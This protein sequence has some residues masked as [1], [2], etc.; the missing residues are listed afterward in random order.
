MWLK[1]DICWRQ[2]CIRQLNNDIIE[3][4]I[5]I[6]HRVRERRM[7]SSR[8]RIT[9][10]NRN[11]QR[12]RSRIEFFINRR[13]DLKSTALQTKSISIS[14]AKH[15]KEIQKKEIQSKRAKE[16][17][18][19][20][21]EVTIYENQNMTNKFLAIM[22]EFN[23]WKE[24]DISVII[25]LKNHM[26]IDLKSNWADKIKSNKIYLLKS[27]KRFIINEIFDNLHAKEKMKWF[28]N[29]TSFEYLVFVI[30]RT[31]MKDDK[32][33]R[34][35]WAVINIRELNAIIVSDAYLMSAQTEIIAAVAQCQYISIINVLEYFYQW[36]IKFD[37]RHKF[38]IIS[39]RDEK[40]FN[41]YVMNYK[42]SSS[43]VQRQTNLMLKNLRNFVRTYMNDIIIFF[44][45]LN[46]HLLHLREIF[47]RLWYYNVVLN[48]KKAFL[49]YSFI[50]LLNQIID[51][52][53]L[54]IAEKKLVAIANLIFSLILKEL[55]FF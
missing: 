20:T 13:R 17:I 51:V 33:V 40:Q 26:S 11:V 35:K 52:L 49:K 44:K 54:I 43:Y 7:L 32:F 41:V 21:N 16:K 3:N 30:Y 14:Y 29:S 55:K 36:A 45:T 28:T 18:K 48:L 15:K 2:K 8:D 38:T 53:K 46:D 50:I 23:V 42:N 25:S 4:T 39:H 22:I 1:S 31:I 27:N 10:V 34:K 9:R 37:D 5:E 47:Q 6:A 19:L 24:H 12:S